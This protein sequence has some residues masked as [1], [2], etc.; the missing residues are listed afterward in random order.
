[1]C[2]FFEKKIRSVI[3]DR[4]FCKR[5][6]WGSYL[7]IYCDGGEPIFRWF[8]KFDKK[9]FASCWGLKGFNMY[10]LGREFSFVFSKDKH[11][12]YC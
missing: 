10:W 1:M 11:K 12:L 5:L 2:N 7:K 4:L 6:Y 9:Y 8:P 3:S